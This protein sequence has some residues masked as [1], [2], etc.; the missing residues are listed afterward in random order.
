MDPTLANYRILI[1]AHSAVGN[2][3][4]NAWLGI[5]IRKHSASAWGA[6][7]GEAMLMWTAHF[8]D[9]TP[10]ASAGA[11]SGA[12]TGALTGQRDGD[13]S[14]TYASPAFGGGGSAA[15]VDLAT[16]SYGQAYLDLRNSRAATS[17]FVPA[18]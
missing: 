11:G 12:A 2:D 5:A 6:V 14:R 15:D 3:T 13:L 8:V 1:P 16:T 17:P 7:Y 4:V 10:G 18:C 9:R